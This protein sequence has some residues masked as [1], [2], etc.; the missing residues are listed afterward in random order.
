MKHYVNIIC[1]TAK[2]VEVSVPANS[3]I[4]SGSTGDNITHIEL[5]AVT[6]NVFIAKDHTVNY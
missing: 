1:E 3:K 6:T 4:T 5:K 2:Q